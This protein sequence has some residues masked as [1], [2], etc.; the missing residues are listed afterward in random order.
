LISYYRA[1]AM[2]LLT[3]NRNIL[4]AL[5]EAL[6]ER[7]TLDGDEVDTIIVDAI[8]ALAV[9]AKRVRRADWRERERNAAHFL[10]RLVE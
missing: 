2:A 9:E 8:S 3:S 6:I 7:G 10:Q 4:D 5:V 1:E